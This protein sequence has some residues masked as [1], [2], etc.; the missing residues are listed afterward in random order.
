MY[1]HTRQE[2]ADMLGISTR[3]IDRYV[4]SGRLR[5]KKDGKVVYI[6]LSDLENLISGGMVNQEII[7]EKKQASNKS[8]NN[9]AY[10][11]TSKEVDFPSNIKNQMDEVYDDLR[12]EIKEKD[13]V[14]RELS[15]RVGRA[16]EIAKN[17]VS[18]IDFKKS[19]FLLEESKTSLN[20]TLSDL[21]AEK[22]TITSEL[23]YQKTNNLILLISLIV[24]FAIAGTIFLIK[25]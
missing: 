7:V 22:E 21:Q 16:E 4:K 5:S 2:A 3:S 12:N 10:F 6:K 8:N 9:E 11:S 17:S 25:I 24:L 1:K 13:V 20:Q 18:L 19:Q 14:I 23:K 15:I